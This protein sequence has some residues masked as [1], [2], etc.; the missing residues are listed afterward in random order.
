MD[1]DG[2]LSEHVRDEL[3]GSWRHKTVRG[4]VLGGG[5]LFILVVMYTV[6]LGTSRY[7]LP[8]RQ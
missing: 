2:R 4:S 5:L 1:E 3:C 7:Y 6:H 8:A